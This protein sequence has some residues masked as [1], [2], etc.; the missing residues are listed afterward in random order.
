MGVHYNAD[1]ASRI[2]VVYR[3][4][5]LFF[6]WVRVIGYALFVSLIAVMGVVVYDRSVR[7]EPVEVTVELGG[8]LKLAVWIL[9]LMLATLG[10]WIGVT[11]HLLFH[12]SETPLFQNGGWSVPALALTGWILTIVASGALGIVLYLAGGQ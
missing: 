3:L 7:V 9:P 11:L 6:Y 8:L 2:P 1:V 4:R 12:R 5:L 10:H